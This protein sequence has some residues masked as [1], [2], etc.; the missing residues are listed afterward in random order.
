MVIVASALDPS[1]KPALIDR[2]IVAA[3]KNLIVPI[4]AINKMDLTTDVAQ[5][6]HIMDELKSLGYHAIRTSVPMQLGI[7]ELRKLMHGKITAFTGQSGV[8]KSSLLNAVHPDFALKTGK[9]S[10]DSKKGKHTTRSTELIPW[11]KQSWVIDTP[12]SVSWNS[13]I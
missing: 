6:E 8:G 1:F 10:G 4:V 11:D 12:E 5:I 7:A 2:F 13:G 9:V 3:E